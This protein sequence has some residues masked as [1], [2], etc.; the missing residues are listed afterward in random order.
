MIFKQFYFNRYLI[1]IEDWFGLE[2]LSSHSHNSIYLN[3]III[4]YLIKTY[5]IPIQCHN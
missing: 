1:L 5:K 4:E 2:L 3:D